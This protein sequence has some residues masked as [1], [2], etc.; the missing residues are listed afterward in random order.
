APGRLIWMDGQWFRLIALDFYDR[1]YVDGRWSEYP[2]FPLFPSAAGLLIK[3]GASPTL[4]LA[5]IS[6]L[7]ALAAMAG[8]YRLALRHLP[9]AAAPWVPWFLA[10]APGAVTMVL[11]YADSLYLAGLIWALVLA[12]DRRWW[13]AGVLAAVATAARPNGWIALVAVVVT[14]LLAKAG[15]RALIAVALPSIAFLAAWFVYLD[16]ATGNPFVFWEA[17][18]AWTELSLTTLLSDPFEY[19]HWPGLFHLA[20]MLALT[21]P[22]LMRVRG[23]PLAWAFVVAL[24]VLPPFVLGVEGLARYA[25][26]AFP[27]SFAAA[28]VLA[29]R[30]RWPAVA[31]LSVSGVGMLVLAVMVNHRSWLP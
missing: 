26:M 20:F 10:I 19:R 14:V 12:E 16:W 29:T 3:L 2:F 15:T 1:P 28:D 21:V 25:V 9:T 8:A 4:A 27:M 5:G 17:K 30:R 22:Y 7:A 24:T 23:Q 13:A 18:D 6:W 31:Y 11:G